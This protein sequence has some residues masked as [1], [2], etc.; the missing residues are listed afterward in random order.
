MDSFLLLLVS[1]EMVPMIVIGQLIYAFFSFWYEQPL[2][3]LIPRFRAWNLV[4]YGSL[5]EDYFKIVSFSLLLGW[6][7]AICSFI[8]IYLISVQVSLSLILGL[9]VNLM[10]I[11]Q[12][13]LICSSCACVYVCV[14]AFFSLLSSCLS[15]HFFIF[16]FFCVPFCHYS[17]ITSNPFRYSLLL[18]YHYWLHLIISC[19]I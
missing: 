7:L 2:Q 11:V 12:I 1:I 14:C 10:A 18:V 16:Y 13:S 4:F 8:L 9:H 5:G 3:A 17:V 19:A 15:T 6:S